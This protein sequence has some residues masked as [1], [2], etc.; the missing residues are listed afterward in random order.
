MTETSARAFESAPVRSRGR[1]RAL[2]AI[3]AAVL[4]AGCAS[5]EPVEP[6]GIADPYESTNRQIHEFNK[7]WD[8]VL[9]RP[10]SRVYDLAM[11]GLG[12]LLLTNA[13]NFLRMPMNFINHTA[14]G[15]FEQ[16]GADVLR[17]GIN[18]VMGLGVLDPATEFGLPQEETDIGETLAVWGVA[19]GPY[20]ELPLLGPAT[21]RDGFGRVA[22]IVLDPFGFFTG[23]DALVTA[24]RGLA[25]GNI[26]RI[27]AENTQVI[28]QAL[29]ESEDSYVT[30]RAG[31]VQYRRRKVAGG[32]TEEALTDV[33]AE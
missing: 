11:P 19:E 28:D 25:V 33:F 10:A 17:T 9:L 23:Y 22:E 20:V 12:D 3:A 29:Y 21:A 5:S 24:R 27:R 26:A 14:Q 2:L 31:Y 8:T 15:D 4:V 32:A 1:R 16:A 13:V 7:G 30:T 6:G 18:L